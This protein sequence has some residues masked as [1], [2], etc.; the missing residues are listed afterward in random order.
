[1]ATLKDIAELAGVSIASVSRVLNQDETFSISSETKLKILQIAQDLQ[2][3]VNKSAAH[4][5]IPDENLKIALIMLY[6]EFW[7]ISDSY[8]LSIRV[9]AKEE[10]AANGVEVKEFFLPSD[11]DEVIDFT[12]F[13]GIIIIGDSGDWYLKENF[14]K[15]VL[16]SRL[17]ISFVDF[18][19]KETDVEADC[20]I[21][22]FRQIVDKAL[23]YFFSLGY[24]EIGYIGSNGCNLKGK[25]H[26]DL[27]CV[28]F[29]EILKV[30]GLY[31]EKYVYKD[32][33]AS[34][35]S[36]YKLAKQ[37]IEKG[38]LPRAFFVE[39]DSM[40]I[41]SLRAFK[42]HNIKIPQQISVIGCNDIPTAEFLTPSLSSV[43]IY[44]DLIGIMS[45]RLMIE[46]IKTKR[47]LGVNIVVPNKLIIR[48]SCE[49]KEN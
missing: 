18:D 32:D 45:T 24:R 27:R 30:Q 47:M 33:N 13:S 1:M 19:P 49:V 23:C 25:K 21:N 36:G 42:E 35:E 41:G 28:S 46:R 15:S 17:P 7:E 12:G 5:F 9:N 22:D 20:V 3:K 29:E 48:Q 11:R 34:A 26:L 4:Q 2:Y 43:H 38:E 39:N 6:S 14:R 37:A 44:S 16:T 31:Q 10:A 8:Y 40:A